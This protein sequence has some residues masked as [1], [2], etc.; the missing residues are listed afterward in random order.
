VIRGQ[1]ARGRT[2]PFPFAVATR[3]Y[4]LEHG[5]VTH[6]GSSAELSRDNNI[7]KA[8]FGV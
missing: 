4:V 8:Y 3:L 5:R 7:R 1:V 2:P 6:A